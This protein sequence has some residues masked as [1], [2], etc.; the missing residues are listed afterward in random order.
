MKLL[1]LTVVAGWMMAALT[2][3][4]RTDAEVSTVQAPIASGWVVEVVG[5]A[6]EAWQAQLSPLRGTAEQFQDQ[7]ARSAPL[8]AYTADWSIGR[9][10]IRPSTAR[11]ALDWAF[12]QGIAGDYGFEHP[13]TDEEVVRHIMDEKAPA[14]VKLIL[15]R[16]RDD[17]PVLRE[18]TWDTIEAADQSIAKLYSGYLGAGGAWEAWRSSLVPGDE[19]RFRLGCNDDVSRCSVIEQHRPPSEN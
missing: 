13:P 14:L 18:M 17:H 12:A 19:A 11:A 2:G 5:T 4:T 6:E 8:E 9:Y 7:A 1:I 16:L 15:A 3:C 10:N